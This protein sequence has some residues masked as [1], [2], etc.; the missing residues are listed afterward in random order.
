MKDGAPFGLAGVWESWKEPATGEWVRTFA[1]ITT[2]ANEL[3]AD[4][5]DRVPVIVAPSDFPRW[6]GEEP[7]ASMAESFEMAASA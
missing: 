6:R 7:D 4:I 2:D 5:H 1:I 3:V